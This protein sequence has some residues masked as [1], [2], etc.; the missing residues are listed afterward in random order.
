MG[1]PVR[2]ALGYSIG[3]LESDPGESP[4]AFGMGGA[5]GTFAYADTATGTAFALT[6]NRLT[7]D[8]DAARKVDRV[9][10]E[11]VADSPPR[12]RAARRPDGRETT[13]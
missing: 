8:F 2:W 6:K 10:T 11:A 1:N 4:T 9:V 7:S 3:R 12:G 5:G 13:A